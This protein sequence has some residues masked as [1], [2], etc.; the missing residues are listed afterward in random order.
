MAIFTKIFKV[1]RGPQ[2][3]SLNTD[4]AGPAKMLTKAPSRFRK[5]PLHST[6]IADHRELSREIKAEAGKRGV[7]VRDYVGVP[8][9]PIERLE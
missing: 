5:P 9:F 4:L 1:Q 8:R 2:T 6:G 7:A 3:L